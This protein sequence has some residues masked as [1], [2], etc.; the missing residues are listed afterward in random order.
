MPKIIKGATLGDAAILKEI[1]N[2][3][4]FEKI[5]VISSLFFNPE[6]SLKKGIYSKTK[7]N[8]EDKNDIKKAIYTLKKL[9]NYNHS[10]GVVIR[11]NK[12]AQIEGKGGTEKML[13]RCKSLK[14]LKSGVLVKFPKKKQDLRI[15]LPTIGLNTLIHCK[16]AGIKG[17]VLKAKQHVFLERDK[18]I[19]FANKNK[20]F[21][22]I[23]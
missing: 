2:I 4:K 1:I 6:L 13:K 23:K 20:M 22:L 15:D 17:I 16:A 18:S 9:G 11:N 21:L 12:I 8:S 7:P 5:N 19:Y 14:T 3:L 10:Q